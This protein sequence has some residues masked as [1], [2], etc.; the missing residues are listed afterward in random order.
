MLAHTRKWRRSPHGSVAGVEA[1]WLDV[2]RLRLAEAGRIDAEGDDDRL[3]GGPC[4]VQAFD[5]VGR[6]GEG[7]LVDRDHGRA[8]PRRGDRGAGAHDDAPTERRAVQGT[9][10]PPTYARGVS[11]RP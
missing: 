10:R 8:G 4:R 7:G 9:A 3:A 11:V 5:R 1:P 6:V 2:D